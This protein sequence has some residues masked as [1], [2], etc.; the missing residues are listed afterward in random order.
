MSPCAG[1]GVAGIDTDKTEDE[2]AAAAHAS[3]SSEG[4][5]DG[6]NEEEEK[7]AVEKNVD[8]IASSGPVRS[9]FRRRRQQQA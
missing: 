8:H 6:S 4:S 5:L 7:E 1:A 9:F 2:N 3:I